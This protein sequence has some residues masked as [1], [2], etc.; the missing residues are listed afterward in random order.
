MAMR[1]GPAAGLEI[2]ERILGRGE[3]DRYQFAHSARGELV[4]RAGRRSDALT[5]FQ[6]A[7][8]RARQEPENR[9]PTA[10]IHELSRQARFWENSG[11]G[12]DFGLAY[13]T[14]GRELGASEGRAIPEGPSLN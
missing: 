12:V 13:S 1:D 4:W 6:K 3:L 14:N 5:A 7:L 2:I 8:E 11:C 9:F 10:R